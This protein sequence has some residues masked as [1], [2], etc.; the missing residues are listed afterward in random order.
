MRRFLILL[1]AMEAGCV[2][3]GMLTDGS[4][5]SVGTHSKGVLRHGTTLPFRGDGYLMPRRWQERQRN[6]GT[7]ELVRLIV[8]AARQVERQ[9]PGGTLGV[10]DLSAS[11]GGSTSEHRSHHSGRDVDLIFYLTDMKG[12]SLVPQEMLYFDKKGLSVVEEEKPSPGEE[13]AKVQ[14]GEKPERKKLDLVRNWALIKALVTDPQ[15][16]VQ[17][18]FAGKPIIRLLLSHARRA[19]EPEELIKRASILLHQPSDSLSHMDHIHLRIFCSLPDRRMG[20]I[21]RGPPR[22]FKKDIKYVDLPPYKAE[23][24]KD[25]ANLKLSPVPLM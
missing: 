18:I 24:P 16:P 9:H 13:K 20:C 2:G 7:D 3:P 25:L 1:L 5:V 10:A 21:D 8:R 6:F 4:A 22:W 23:I 12:K 15:V 11:G 14:E 17:W 19:K